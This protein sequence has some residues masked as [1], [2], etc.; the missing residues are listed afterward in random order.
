MLFDE[1]D[2]ESA[3]EETLVKGSRTGPL[4]NRPG[5]HSPGPPGVQN[6]D[7]HYGKKADSAST[8]DA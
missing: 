2:P 7:P 4:P 5:N 3:L 6:R 8:R 1:T